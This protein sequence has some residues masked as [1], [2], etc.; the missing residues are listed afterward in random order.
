VILRALVLLAFL[1]VA[2]PGAASA[3]QASEPGSAAAARLDAGEIHNC[4]VVGIGGLLRCW[5]FSAD[6]QLGYAST[7]TVGDDEAPGSMPPVDLG[8]GRTT[9]AITAGGFHTCATLDSG[10]VR[11]WGSGF[12]GQL[13]RPH[14][15]SDVGDNET[16]GSV[17]PVDLGA[18]RTTIGM[19][20]GRGHTCAVLDGGDVR[21]WGHGG[22]GRLGYAATLPIGDDESPAA[23][24]PVDLGAGRTAV[25]VSA[26]GSHTCA[27]LDGGDVRCWGSG[28]SGALGHGG[29]DPNAKLP[30]GRPDP[31]A[32]PPDIG[33]DETPAQSGPPIV[34]GGGRAALA[35]S[36][37]GDHTCAVLD[38]RSVRCWG[39]NDSGQLGYGNKLNVAA[40]DTVAAVDLGGQQAQAISAGGSHTCALLD[41]GQVRC[42]GSG[43]SGQLGYGDLEPIGDDESPASA[44]TVDLGPGRTAVA[45]SL[46]E[47]HSC[48]RLDDGNVR[49]WGFADNGRLGYCSQAN[50]GDDETPGSAGPVALTSPFGGGCRGSSPAPPRRAPA[51]V[52]RAISA[53][54]GLQA[55]AARLRGLRSCR[56]R[57]ARHARRE[58]GRA[59]GL[60]GRARARA[61]RHIR[62]HRS[63]SL[64]GCLKRYGRTP[65][66]V[67]GLGARATSSRSVVLTF[68]AP[69]THGNR[70]PAARAY[71][72][73][74]SS[75][76]IRSARSFRRGRSLCD[77]SCRFPSIIQ[78][79]GRIALTVTDLTPGRT[80][81]Y[82]VAAR[83]NVSRRL[84]PRSQTVRVRTP[85]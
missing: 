4:A 74:Q 21:C 72:V 12:E 69:G 25:A 56:A 70:P 51:P 71:V 37:G 57:A 85:R 6:G 11:C 44:G 61:R 81:Y 38:D 23:A 14:Q 30:D 22:R 83:D 35:I 77:G 41:N 13:G 48:A 1:M 24:G 82:A 75:R 9:S 79:G 17:P 45:I 7:E 20:A 27:L 42:W 76:P 18:G 66:R 8:A 50:V 59:R 52:A 53:A 78:V 68:N 32:R 34:F 3:E 65:G 64:R 63:R 33:D 54:D 28:F 46:G 40:P 16:P 62:R 58:S 67:K 60:S 49:C 10:S 80:Y 29:G 36:A 43:D 5:G 2:V 73:K 15:L 84:G 26:G 19:S 31:A 47:R 55:Q 39:L